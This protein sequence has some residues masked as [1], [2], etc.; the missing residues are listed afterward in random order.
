MI[1][2][3]FGALAAAT[4]PVAPAASFQTLDL[5]GSRLTA[6]SAD[7]CVAA[8][9]VPGGKPAGF[10]WSA[11][12]GARPLDSATAVHA[13]SPGGDYAAGAT[14]DAQQREV[15]TWWDTAG[16]PHRVAPLPG[17]ATIGSISQA[18]AITDERWV[19]GSARR[20]DGARVA[21]S[22][23]TT[24]GMHLLPLTGDVVDTRAIAISADG[25]DVAGWGHEDGRV[26]PLHWHDGRPLP[27][28]AT[29][30]RGEILGAG[31]DGRILIGLFDGY[32]ITLIDRDTGPRPIASGTTIRLHASSDDGTLLVGDG[33]HGDERDAWVW[34]AAE[35]L[36]PLRDWLARRG[37]PLAA[38]WHPLALTAV[39]ADGRRLG[40][41]GRRSDNRLD[42]FVVDLG[43]TACDQSGNAG[44]RSPASARKRSSATSASDF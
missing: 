19:V 21:F 10:R 44:S 6:L 7:G 22:W 4:S 25:R 14:L 11:A 34:T 42:S 37:T 12:H 1:P 17:L 8:G 2:S 3:L 39:S 30:E 41:W 13:L 5:P 18:H 43:G 24:R 26:R 27:T 29:T 31:R 23:T 36:V 20:N 16:K 15:A 40:G 28:T 33:G 38:D 32:G 9:V 35:G